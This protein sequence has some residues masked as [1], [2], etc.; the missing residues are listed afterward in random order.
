VV[1][2]RCNP[3]TV[4]QTNQSEATRL[5]RLLPWDGLSRLIHRMQGVGAGHLG[6]CCWYVGG[7]IWGWIG[8]LVL[9][10]GSLLLLKRGGMVD[11]MLFWSN[12]CGLHGMSRVY[13][14]IV[15]WL[16]LLNQVVTVV[17]RLGRNTLVRR[18]A[19]PEEA[20]LMLT[21]GI[22][23][24]IWGAIPNGRLRGVL[25]ERRWGEGRFMDLRGHVL[26]LGWRCLLD[27][28]PCR[29]LMGEVPNRLSGTWVRGDGALIGRGV[30]NMRDRSD[31]VLILRLEGLQSFRKLTLHLSNLA[32]G[33]PDVGQ[34]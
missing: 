10:S 3:L 5:G 2:D 32:D 7:D 26:Y 16:L 9:R 33:C 14:P 18:R 23:M 28:G 11:P 8:C 34:H 30:M 22:G 4:P 15:L 17:P 21:L 20:H 29:I 13:V 6:R 27:A 24:S 12:W 31:N 25:W 1:N 19:I